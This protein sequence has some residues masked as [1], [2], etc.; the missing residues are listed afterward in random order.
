MQLADVRVTQVDI[1]N[2]DY[3]DDDD[4]D[5]DGEKTMTRKKRTMAW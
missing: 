5:G 2:D 4:N 1:V 3:E